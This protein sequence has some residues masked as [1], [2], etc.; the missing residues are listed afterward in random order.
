LGDAGDVEEGRGEE[1]RVGRGSGERENGLNY[2]RRV[3]LCYGVSRSRRSS[4]YVPDSLRAIS[5]LGIDIT[6]I[7]RSVRFSLLSITINSIRT[8][9]NH[10][11]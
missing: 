9:E 1:W 7:I 10:A 5:V 2:V 11:I 8:M 4:V 3:A 6:F